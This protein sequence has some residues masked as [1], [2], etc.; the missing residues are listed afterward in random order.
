MKS[1]PQKP[2][3]QIVQA[4]SDQLAEVLDW[5]K[6]AFQDN[7]GEGFWG[8]RRLIKHWHADGLM[9]V[10][11]VEDKAVGFWAGHFDTNS[12]MEIHRDFR[13]HGY[14][15]L[16]AEDWMK[17]AEAAGICVLKIECSPRSSIP[18]WKKLGFLPLNAFDEFED[19]YF[20][21]FERDLQPPKEGSAVKVILEWHNEEAL[22]GNDVIPLKREEFSGVKKGKKVY[23]PRRFICFS[24][25][26]PSGDTV[27]RIT[28]D[29]VLRYSAKA[30]REQA[31]QLGL[32]QAP[33]YTPYI[34]EIS[35]AVEPYIEGIAS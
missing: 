4:N 29:N 11:L 27:L 7:D 16:L 23:L 1:I 25:Q 6:I 26:Q 34:D 18:F 21:V 2:P 17:G 20:R 12:V 24:P 5:L 14:G 10:L 9:R 33:C 31:R 8:N 30:K 35:L 15:R 19:D 3:V 22:W 32:K 28:I 13:K